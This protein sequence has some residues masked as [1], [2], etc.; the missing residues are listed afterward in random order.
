MLAKSKATDRHP[1]QADAF[2]RALRM[3]ARRWHAAGSIQRIQRPTIN[4]AASLPGLGGRAAAATD[5]EQRLQLLFSCG[6]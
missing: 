2:L 6:F 3:A 4:E 1:N 5:L